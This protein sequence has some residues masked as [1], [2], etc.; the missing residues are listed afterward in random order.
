MHVDNET[1]YESLRD[2]G[3]SRGKDADPRNWGALNFEPSELDVNAQHGALEAWNRT[4]ELEC[5][6][7]EEPASQP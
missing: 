2:E 7:K 6:N 1:G 5:A 3:P 4:R